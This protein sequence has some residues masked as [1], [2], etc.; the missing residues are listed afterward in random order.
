MK[1]DACGKKVSTWL[2]W[3]KEKE[4]KELEGIKVK[5]ENE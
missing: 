1:D 2:V 4:G 3:I 5:V